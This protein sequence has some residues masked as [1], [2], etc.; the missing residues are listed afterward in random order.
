MNKSRLVLFSKGTIGSIQDKPWKAAIRF[1]NFYI[2]SSPQELRSTTKILYL[3]PE[4][5]MPV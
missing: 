2:Y 5:S 1:N 3:P 4:Q